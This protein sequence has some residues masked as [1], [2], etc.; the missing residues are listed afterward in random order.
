MVKQTIDLENLKQLTGTRADTNLPAY[1]RLKEQFATLRAAI[2]DCRFIYLLGQKADG[3]LFFY[4]DNEPPDSKDYSPPGQVYT[5]APDGFR[6]GFARRESVTDGP[7]V[8]RWGKW[9]S[10]AIPIPDPRMAVQG[11]ATPAQAQALV[12]Q[13]LAFYRQNGRERLLRELNDPNGQFCKGELF[14]FA[15]DRQMTLL[16][17]PVKPE[18]VGQNLLDKKDWPGGKYFRREIQQVA[19]TQGTGWVE[20]EYE[21]PL[22]RQ[23][24]HKTTWVV[25]T[26]DLVIC[27]GA[28]QDDSKV[29]ALL[30]LDVGAQAWNGVLIR[31][32]LPPLLC[33]LILS[34]L[35]LVGV[36][37]QMRQVRLKAAQVQPRWNFEP[38]LAAGIGLVLTGFA[39]WMIYHRELN[40]RQ[41]A[42]AQLAEIRSAEVAEVLKDL[43]DSDLAGLAEFCQ[44]REP[45]RP[46]KFDEY[47]TCLLKNHVVQAWAWI[48][49]VPAPE[50]TN[51]EA[52]TSGGLAGQIWQKDSSGARAPV[53]GRPFYYPVQF[54]APLAGNQAMPDFDLGSE[55]QL[56]P[57][58]A[59]AGQSRLD[60]ASDPITLVQENSSQKC[61]WIFHPV[62][63]RARPAELRGMVG[64]VLRLQALLLTSAP[65][66]FADLQLVHLHAK[67]P[68][69]LLV[70]SPV[71]AGG[72]DSELVL[73]RPVFAFGQTLGLTVRAGPEFMRRHPLQDGWL[74]G[75]TGGMV[76]VALAILIQ[77]LVRR[78]EQLE[79]QV[80]A[81][82]AD[83]RDRERTLRKQRNVLADIIDGT[84]VGTWRWAVQTGQAEYNERWAEIAGYTLADLAPVDIQ[85]WHK[86]LHPEDL[87]Q[88]KVLLHEHFA[89]RHSYYDFECRMRHKDGSWVWVHD[90]GKVAE[91]DAAGQPLVMT[92]TL[93]DITRRKRAEEALARSAQV[94]EKLRNAIIAI[95]ACENMDEALAC[96]MR[97]AI[98]LGRID[99]AAVYLVEGQE[100]VLR[101]Q[102]GLPEE[103]VRQVARRPLATG[104]VAAA[105][106]RPYEIIDAGLLFPEAR[107]AGQVYGIQHA[108]WIGLAVEQEPLALLVLASRAPEP[109]VAAD[110]EL[111]RIL[112]REAESLFRRL[113]VELSL[114]Q[115]TRQ[116]QMILETSSAGIALTINRVVQWTNP[117]FREIFGYDQGRVVGMAAS[118]LYVRSEDYQR[119]GQLMLARF[120][121]G[122]A[123]HTEA[124]LRRQDGTSIWCSITGR[125]VNPAK[126][127]EGSIWIT[128][129][130]TAQRQADQALR[131]SVSMLQATLQSTAD[132]ILVV[133][134][135]FQ[136]VSYNQQFVELMRVPP[137]LLASRQDQPV[138]EH[139]ARQMK[140]PEA[141]VARVKALHTNLVGD[142]FEVLE[143]ADG[144]IYERYS[145]PQL[146]EGQPVARVWSFRDV[147]KR[148]RAEAELR[149]INQELELTTIRANQMAARAEMANIAKSQFLA[150]MSHEIRTP[151]NGILGMTGLLLETQLDADQREFALLVQSS[152]QTL[153]AL[154]NDILDFS[155][156]EA[157]K[158]E[159][160]SLDFNLPFLLEETLQLMAVKAAEKG[161]KLVGDVAPE[162]PDFVCGDSVRLQQ[163]LL[164]LGGNG[165]KFTPA[166]EVVIRVSVESD[167]ERQVTLRFVVADSGVGI[168]ADQMQLLFAPFTQG[169]AS[170]TR[171]FGG[172][173]L[174]LAISK[175]LVEKM[176]GQIGVDSAV[177]QGSTFWFTATFKRPTGGALETGGGDERLRQ[178]KVLVLEGHAASRQA[179]V[180]LLERLGCQP[181]PAD[182][183]ETAGK[184]AGEAVRQGAPFRVLLV[185]R[186][187]CAVAA[188]LPSLAGL[189][190]VKLLLFG[191]RAGPDELARE[192]LVDQLSKPLRR[193]ALADCL[194]RIVSGGAALLGTL[195]PSAPP[196]R[197][198]L[199]VLLAEDNLVNQLL[200]VKLLKGLGHQV[201]AAN[202]GR[203][204]LAVL[205]KIPCDL[206]LM[207]CR[208]EPMGGMETA[209][210]IR[211]GEAGEQNRQIPI[212][213]C[214]AGDVNEREECR[215][216]QMDDWLEKPLE[217]QKL[218]R[219]LERWK[220]GRA[221]DNPSGLSGR[222]RPT[223]ELESAM[224]FDQASLLNR[225]SGDFEIIRAIASGFLE[226]LPMQLAALTAAQAAGRFETVVEVT[227]RLKG[228][229][230]TIAASRLQLLLVELEN[231]VRLGQS[232]RVMDILAGVEAEAVVF[233][234]ELERFLEAAAA[235]E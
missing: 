67:G 1:L 131:Q 216:A 107:A 32:A 28:Y 95:Q 22:N 59:T 153:L 42:F 24:D 128:V 80:I 115:I 183:L 214:S 229:A 88:A 9:V 96:L 179:I 64:C 92:G 71:A 235:P 174:G 106:A 172:T 74:A 227:H 168:P 166:G 146:I 221:Q 27:A 198:H 222:H 81:Q 182:D 149:E 223:P 19:N 224:I 104:H 68:A 207:D 195:P 25:G 102:S 52:G 205:N 33:T 46:E 169:D 39:G 196:V 30:C 60:T 56:R 134:R 77:V 57:A 87:E 61:L 219:V 155:K 199:K 97:Q 123:Y 171:K 209:R 2:P 113:R 41:E 36:G 197:R 51:Y 44:D 226:D 34:G 13:V 159:L 75:L 73:T 144:R 117:A 190:R 78:R 133:D 48:P 50:K 202:N 124:E 55:P 137:E 6:R 49:V 191:Q 18:L 234:R 201:Y 126:L 143:F 116:Q 233:R 158:L 121:R 118:A 231:A 225:T 164:N 200:A 83:L 7:Y 228:A 93:S 210:R 170:T 120:A 157:G 17:H 135:N 175:Q 65:D 193:Q 21:N 112:A 187:F 3:P 129:D 136:V 208:M 54:V 150:C 63:S 12:D 185:D 213:A 86:L 110:L 156:I 186:A 82:T 189:L 79:L 154:I 140:N 47:S 206:V 127:E 167:D 122:E 218:I 101:H 70:A 180:D 45:L 211:H 230:G 90:R 142:S 114:R 40:G 151:M 37:C 23:R 14:A 188:T 111:I 35:L 217:K 66:L 15:Y 53:A 165:V 105:L 163:I 119:V 145:R 76:T 38:W 29:M 177:G 162:V 99:S 160:E 20:Y 147:T 139:V 16:A 91:R 4:L 141:F 212:I 130:I 173:G 8:D 138:L 10:A 194:L 69:E 109:P 26:N 181:Q 220:N 204:V 58:L 31:A 192:G 11:L 85:T 152:G 203:E 84:H 178:L 98:L 184:L 232:A 43:G 89:G 103:F 161:L 215:L 132:G 108:Y 176:H 100:A 94:N 72:S 5:E 125:A 62:F 148:Y